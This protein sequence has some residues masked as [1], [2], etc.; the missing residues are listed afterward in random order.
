MDQAIREDKAFDCPVEEFETDKEDSGKCQ[1]CKHKEGGPPPEPIPSIYYLDEDDDADEDAD[2]GFVK[3]EK[4]NE[5][6]EVAEPQ[7]FNGLCTAIRSLA[8][9]S[10]EEYDQ[11]KYRKEVIASLWAKI[12]KLEDELVA[13]ALDLD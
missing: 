1:Q 2:E 11:R 5:V 3:V 7:A 8:L 4:D 10:K 12:K 13:R 6:G 9:Q